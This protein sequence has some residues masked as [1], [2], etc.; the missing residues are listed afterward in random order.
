MNKHR[1][2]KRSLIA[3]LILHALMLIMVLFTQS[4][5]KPKTETVTIELIDPSESV[6]QNK[7]PEQIV[8]QDKAINDELSKDAKFLSQHNQT[9]KKQTVSKN[10]GEFKNQT[11][12][13]VAAGQQQNQFSPQANKKLAKFVPKL[14]LQAGYKKQLV[15]EQAMAKGQQGSAQQTE[16]SQTRDYLKNVDEGLQTLLTTREFVY[17]SYYNRIRGQ[18]AQ[19]WEPLIKKK[20]MHIF[21]Q[22]RTIA[23]TDDKITKVMIILDPKGTLIGVQVLGASG[24]RDLDDAAVEAFRAAA[25][26]PNPP[27]GIVEKDGTI[28]IRWDFILEA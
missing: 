26:F 28:K 20:I 5:P 10:H 17:Y 23:S 22:G 21:K 16:V 15:R 9:V 6:T 2:F 24:L 13:S 14:D 19:H 8:E 1:L 27:A 11:K 7:K 25:P 4:E 18:L 12:N 3:S